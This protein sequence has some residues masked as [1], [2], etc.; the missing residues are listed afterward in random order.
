VNADDTGPPPAQAEVAE[1]P[2]L[3]AHETGAAQLTGDGDILDAASAGRLAT[4]GGALRVGSYLGGALAGLGAAALLYRHLGVIEVGRYGLILAL[5]AIVAAFSD[6]GLTAVG[7]RSASTETPAGRSAMLRDLLGLRLALTVAG[8]GAIALACLAIYPSIVA[9]G[10]LIGGVALLLQECLDNYQISLV[11]DLRMG[12]VA[13]I[14]LAGS[15]G[16]AVLTAALVFAGAHLLTFVAIAIPVA[17]AGAAAAAR[18]AR[19]DRSLLPSFSLERWRALFARSIVYSAAVAAGVLYFYSAIVITSL[20]AN[21]H[22]LGYFQLSFRVT[23]V[24][25]GIPGLLA[26]SAFPIFSRAA[27]D[28]LGRLGYA[29]GRVFEVSLLVGAW[30][31][32]SLAVGARFA[33]E[34]VGGSA[35]THNFLPAAPVLSFQAV[36]LGGTFMGSVASFGLLSLGLNR[37][38]LLLNV[39]GLVGAVALMCV[40]VPL[41]GAQGAAIGTMIGEVGAAA[42]G[43][44]VLGTT[45]AELWPPLRVVPR[46][47][48]A[49]IVGAAPV[50]LTSWPVLTRVM[51]SSVL[52]GAIVL[53]TKAFPRELLDLLPARL[54]ARW[55]GR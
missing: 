34:L 46:I 54:A 40:L 30:V 16:A 18:L 41:D 32:L 42:A 22:Q 49:T 3:G 24:L 39:T 25:T 33:V 53:A 45:H 9:L 35:S 20:L 15:V 10:V 17:A 14:G 13:A 47:A 12:W 48:L 23:T 6:L 2:A 43:W 11:V 1:G 28:D 50:L 36:A 29:L 26:I 38:I 5:V 37:Q 7:I 8:I 19:D 21:G 52:Y 4:R 51:L 44:V 55:P 31:A 27:R